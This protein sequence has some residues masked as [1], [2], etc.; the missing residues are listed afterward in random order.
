L[1]AVIAVA[2]AVACTSIEQSRSALPTD[3]PAMAQL[4]FLNEP[5]LTRD[6]VVARLGEPDALFE[7]GQIVGYDVYGGA[8]AMSRRPGPGAYC[9]GLMVEYSADGVVARHA[10]IRHGSA[11]CRKQQ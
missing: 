8:K 1:P 10:L 6:L 3:D 7:G 4:G 5:G 9:F 11:R 2:L